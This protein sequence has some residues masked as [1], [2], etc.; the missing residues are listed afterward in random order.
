MQESFAHTGQVACLG[1]RALDPADHRELR[2]E[3]AAVFYHAL[4]T[5]AGARVPEQVGRLNPA[6]LRPVGDH[7]PRGVGDAIL[8]VHHLCA[9]RGCLAHGIRDDG[10]GVVAEILEALKVRR[11]EGAVVGCELAVGDTVVPRREMHE[12]GVEGGGFFQ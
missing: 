4:D 5:V 11:D 6:R 3:R 12:N 2:P 7:M 9:E 10:Y 8:R 1:K